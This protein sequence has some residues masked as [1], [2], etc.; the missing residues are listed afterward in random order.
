MAEVSL[1]FRCATCKEYARLEVDGRHSGFDDSVGEIKYW[2][3]H[4][5]RCGSPGLLSECDVGA[6]EPD[7]T[8][9]Y[10]KAGLRRIDFK[11]PPEVELSYLE[12]MRCES[13]EAWLATA[14]MVRRTMEAVGKEFK[15]SAR[16]L[17]DGLKAMRDQGAISDELMEWGTELRFLG[18]VGAHP[19]GQRVSQQDATDAMEFLAA[20]VETI[21]QLRPKFMAMRTRR[22]VAKAAAAP[23]AAARSTNGDPMNDAESASPETRLEGV[24]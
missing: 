22:Q 12:A 4:C 14:V 7:E 23:A 13:A 20:I 18:N 3:G 11:M 9:L 16:N 2:F 5:V 19:G 6:H 15:P 10:P 17:A 1:S 24:P 21:Y 8:Q